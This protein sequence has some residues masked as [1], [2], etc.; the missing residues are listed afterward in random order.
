MPEATHW[1]SSSRVYE[2]QRQKVD[3]V[4]FEVIHHRLTLD[5]RRAGGDA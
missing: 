2:Y 4:T 5:H 3:P 1:P